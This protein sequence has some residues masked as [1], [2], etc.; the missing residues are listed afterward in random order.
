[1]YLQKI[2][3]MHKGYSLIEL[4]IVILIVSMVYFLG[5]SGFEKPKNEPKA[6]TALN[7]KSTIMKAEGYHGKATL[8]CT[9]KCRLCY[10][11]KG[12]TGM[13]KPYTHGI[14]LK[15]TEAYTVDERD[16]LLRLEYGRYK[17]E[18]V[19]LVIDFYNNGS[20]TQ[21][22]LKNEDGIFFLPSF[23]QEAQ[24]VGALSDAKALW[25]KNSDL[26]SD[27]GKFY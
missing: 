23:F 2:A 12:V 9:K 27:S 16:S 15:N 24:K 7:L 20:S 6:L 8:M 4:L 22:I 10:L 11:R 19:C 1:M 17:D 25:L 3:P 26:V 18:K 13:F 5:F 21:I 14:D